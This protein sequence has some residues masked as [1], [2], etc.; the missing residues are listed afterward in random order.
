MENYN[1]LI[2][3][4]LNGDTPREKYEFLKN[5]IQHNIDVNEAM[6]IATYCMKDGRDKSVIINKKVMREIGLKLFMSVSPEFVRIFN[7]DNIL[8]K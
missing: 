4:L 1:N 5:Q 6:A 7:I 8:Q 2:M 3:G